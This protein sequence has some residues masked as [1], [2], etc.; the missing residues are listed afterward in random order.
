[1]NTYETES[2]GIVGLIVM[3][4]YFAAI[5]INIVAL[6][7]VFTKAEQPG[8]GA[9]IPLYNWYVMLKIAGRPGWWFILSFIPIVN[10]ITLIVPFDIAKRFGKGTGFGLGM[11]LLGPIFFPIL[12]FSDA[13]YQF[14]AE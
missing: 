11:L 2:T 13:E 9:V 8:W 1:M 7:K 14:T 10:L 5:I 3:A 12:G 4:I 6:W